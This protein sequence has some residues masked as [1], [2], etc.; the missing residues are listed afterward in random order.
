LAEFE[1]YGTIDPLR[2]FDNKSLGS[3]HMFLKKY[4]KQ[5]Y[6]I[7]FSADQELFLEFISRKFASGKRPHEL[8][9]LQQILNG[10]TTLFADLEATLWE[11]YQIR[12]TDKCTKNLIN[13]LTN[14][15]ATGTGAET[16]AKCILIQAN[17]GDYCANSIFA[18]ML[19]DPNFRSAITELVEF[20]LYRNQKD[21]G[22]LYSES[23]FQLYA[24]YTYEDVCRLLNWEKGEVALNIG[25]YK[26]DKN[27]KTYPVFIN[28]DKSEDIVETTRYEDR[29]IDQSSLIAISKSKRTIS[30]DDVHTA[31]HADELGVI[32]ELFVRKNKDDKISKEF[33]YLG[34][35]HATGEVKEFIMPNTTASAVEISYALETPVRDDIFN[36][37]TA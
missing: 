17:N 34:R 1:E 37:I 4:E 25:G 12:M 28:Y 29:F 27:T 23:A 5:D 10:S 22:N 9:I 32:M 6:K 21:Y 2:I 19:S 13:V 31:L 3:Y 11:S 35:I 14:K 15:F 20:G 33:Y 7:K 26:Y 18:D 36:Y 24:K 16:Y 30:S 8:I